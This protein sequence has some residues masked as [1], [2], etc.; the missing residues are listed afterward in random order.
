M[1]EIDRARDIGI[2]DPP[3]LFEILVQKSMPE[4]SSGI[5]QKRV[6]LTSLRGGIK[7]IDAFG[8]RKVG[9]KG[10]NLGTVGSKGSRRLF[11]LRFVSCDQEVL[12]FLCAALGQFQADARRR[13]GDDRERSGHN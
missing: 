10:F 2:N 3:R 1:D 9:L 12:A 7:L 5:R 13:T 8:G 11:D 6:H 4:T